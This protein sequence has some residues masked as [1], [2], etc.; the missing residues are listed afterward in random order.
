MFDTSSIGV[1]CT[2]ELD[3]ILWRFNADPQP[4]SYDTDDVAVTCPPSVTD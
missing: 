3:G 2:V 1:G 4:H